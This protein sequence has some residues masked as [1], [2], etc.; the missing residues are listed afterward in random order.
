MLYGTDETL[1]LFY[2]LLMNENRKL[3]KTALAIR[4]NAIKKCNSLCNRLSHATGHRGD[5]AMD[6][7]QQWLKSVHMTTRST[8]QQWAPPGI[9][10]PCQIQ[11]NSQI[12]VH[13][14]SLRV[15]AG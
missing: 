11:V 13:G 6:E 14:N 10:P 12:Q 9:R 4:R 1:N 5:E 7:A 15:F 3:N 8:A 2:F